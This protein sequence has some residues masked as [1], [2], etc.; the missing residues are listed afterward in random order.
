LAN[1]QAG[2]QDAHFAVLRIYQ[3]KKDLPTAGFRK[4]LFL[5][6]WLHGI[7]LAPLPVTHF[8]PFEMFCQLCGLN[9]TSHYSFGKAFLERWGT[10][11]I[12]VL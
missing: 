8:I 11:G 10:V 7:H 9:S 2:L 3:S 1:P 4:K 6:A 5:S 12:F